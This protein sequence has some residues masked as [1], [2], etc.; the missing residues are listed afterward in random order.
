M[1][2]DFNARFDKRK[3][4]PNTVPNEKFSNT[5]TSVWPNL[6]RK[7]I[8]VAKSYCTNKL[9]SVEITEILDVSEAIFEI[10]NYLDVK[11]IFIK[12]QIIVTER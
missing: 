4:E 12:N 10:P 6:S 7:I 8:S 1:C 3:V 11:D 2:S 5:L 9:N